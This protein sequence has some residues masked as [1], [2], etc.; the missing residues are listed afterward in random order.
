MTNEVAEL[1][2]ALHDGKIELDEVARRF[3]ER[4]WPQYPG[5]D[6]KNYTELAMSA[7]KDPEPYIAGSYDDVALAYHQGQLTDSQYTVLVDS[8]AESRRIHDEID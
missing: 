1:I 7:A 2:Q 4:R 6:P 8:I 5:S 3:K